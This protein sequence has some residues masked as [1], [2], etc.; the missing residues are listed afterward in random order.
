MD[1]LTISAS[2]FT[3][4]GP[5][6]LVAGSVS[7]DEVNHVAV[8]V[9]DAPL[10]ASAIHTASVST[11][12]KDVAGNSLASVFTW[13]FTTGTTS[14]SETPTVTSTTPAAG[15]VAVGINTQIVARF[16]EAMNASTISFTLADTAGAVAGSVSY[17]AVN[18][19]ASFVPAAPLAK[20]T[21]HTATIGSGATDSAGNALAAAFTW[22][23]DT[24]APDT[25]AP[26][27]TSTIPTSGAVG[28]S[29]NATVT[30]TFSETMDSLTATTTSFTLKLNGMTAV[31]GTVNCPGTTATFT[32]NASLNSGSSYTATLSTSLTDLAG[33]PLA[34]SETWT[35]ETGST[36]SKGPGSVNLGTAGNFVALAKSGVSTTGVTAIDGNVGLSPAA[37][38]FLTGFSETLDSTNQ[39]STA[40][41][42]SGK[43]FA[44]NYA[45]PTPA[46]MT[47]AVSDMETAYT[48]AAGC[49][50]P[51]AT[52]L[53][54]GD[55]SGL[56]IAPGLYKWGTGVL[57]TSSVTLNGGAN[58]TW[59]FQIAG[60]LTIGN[61]AIVTL[62][63]GAQAKNVVWQVAGQSVL[64]TTSAFKGIILCQ[65]QIVFQTGAVSIGRALAQTAITLDATTLTSP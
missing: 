21:T 62:S 49:T 64:R 13:S 1:A 36:A 33:N 10:A 7:Y 11:G 65:T 12:A 57:V 16:S 34:T 54:A 43:L 50:T 29:L 3:L 53:G 55:L 35:F 52:E 38:S 47:A 20:S 25:T 18:H 39:F 27:V 31:T 23:F 56:V 19:V 15:A 28:V 14:D 32:P 4:V 41:V 24:D 6:G 59:I 5:A 40:P 30:A 22:T 8:F 2:T 48:D 58:D 26:T 9:P 37:A 45:P 61:G 17:D 46:N 63:G 44:A 60:D 42:V 51:D